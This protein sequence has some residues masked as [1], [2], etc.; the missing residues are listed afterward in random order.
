MSHTNGSR[1]CSRAFMQISNRSM[2]WDC[3][4]VPYANLRNHLRGSLSIQIKMAA[5][6]VSRSTSHDNTK[7]ADYI[8]YVGIFKQF[9]LNKRLNQ[10]IKQF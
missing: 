10:L 4:C 6:T 8:K 9:S 2:S 3:A 7:G 5:V 1:T